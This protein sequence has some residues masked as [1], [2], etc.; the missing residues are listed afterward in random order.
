[1]LG[2]ILALMIAVG[3]GQAQQ[4]V[5]VFVQV[6]NE[7]CRGGVQIS[8]FAFLRG[9]NL[10]G[11]KLFAPPVEIAYGETRQFEFELGD[12]PTAVNIRGTINRQQPLEVTAPVG[13]TEYE[14]GLI[15]VSVSGEQPTEGPQLPPELSGIAPGMPPQQVISR[16][17]A[18]GFDLEVQGSEAEPKFGNVDDPLIIG[19]L[20]PGFLTGVG[21]WASAPG[22][23]RSA[24]IFDRPAINMVLLV[25]SNFGGF[26]FSITPVGG[27]LTLFCDRPAVLAPSTTFGGGPVPGTVFLVLVL[28]LGGPTQPFVLS[29]SG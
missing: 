23:L 24:V 10:L 8:Q 6:S 16:L 26:C 20:G 1:M 17:Q 27:G 4:P 29:L 22:Q 25:V 15:Q 7:G 11:V 5:Q 28:K 9:S 13:V 18:N 2:L 19:A 3:Y 12:A 14:C 21:Y